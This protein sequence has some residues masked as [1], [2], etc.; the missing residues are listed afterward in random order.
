MVMHFMMRRDDIALAWGAW[1]AYILW[2]TYVAQSENRL[3]RMWH[4]RNSELAKYSKWRKTN[5][6]E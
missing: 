2:V 5:V 6:L 1:G 3:H 4:T